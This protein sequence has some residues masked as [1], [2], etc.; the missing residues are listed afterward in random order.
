MKPVRSRSPPTRPTETA[1]E[2]EVEDGRGAVRD[3]A[4]EL[5]EE[6]VAVDVVVLRGALVAEGSEGEHADGV[7]GFGRKAAITPRP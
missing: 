5:E 2:L 1:A 6:A 4:A 3:A 7:P